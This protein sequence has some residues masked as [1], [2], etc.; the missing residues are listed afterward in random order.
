MKRKFYSSSI[1]LLFLLLFSAA[2]SL[3]EEPSEENVKRY[4]ILETAKTYI[5]VKYS[6]GGSGETGF[7]CSGFVMFI[8]SIHNIKLARSSDKQYYEAKKITKEQAYPGDLVFFTT[9]KKGPSHV[10]IYMGGDDFIHSP[11]TGKRVEIATMN[12]SYWKKR[13][14]GFGTYL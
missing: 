14:I 7:D 13:I 2:S 11:S 6:Y 12:N 5:G 10:G 8:Y 4:E 1:I 3:A 9:Y